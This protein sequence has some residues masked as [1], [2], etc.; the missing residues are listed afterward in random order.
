MSFQHAATARFEA[1]LP[2]SYAAAA[3]AAGV[4][5]RH[6]RRARANW[7]ARAI[8]AAGIVNVG[9]VCDVSEGGFGMMSAV[10]MPVGSTLEV[11]L[12]VPRTRDGGRSVPVRCKVRVVASNFAG[13]QTRMSL[14]FMALPKESRIAIRHY[15]LSHS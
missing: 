13:E 2:V 6:Q 10:H 4:E 14:Q 11:A 8:D 9:R 5:Q 7:P 1:A 15:V 3:H 12:A